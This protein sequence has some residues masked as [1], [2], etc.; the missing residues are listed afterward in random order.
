NAYITAAARCV[1]PDNKPLP[2][3]LRNCGDYLE[4]ELDLLQP[5]AVLALGAIAF[6]AYLHLLLRRK[7]IPNRSAYA[8][9][10]G[11]EIALPNGMPHLFASYHP[12]QQNT[13]TGRLTAEM[14]YSVLLRIRKVI[15]S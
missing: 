4:K 6:N 12:S 2:E 13:Q 3:E 5:R 1:P 14:F 15:A 8:F 11:A 10:H 7:Q 9:S